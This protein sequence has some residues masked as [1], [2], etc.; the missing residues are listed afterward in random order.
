MKK[1]KKKAETHLTPPEIKALVQYA[2]DNPDRIRF[3]SGVSGLVTCD[4]YAVELINEK[5]QMSGVMHPKCAI[6]LLLE[7]E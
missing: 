5:G 1:K 2:K 3:V 7:S 4:G 6:D